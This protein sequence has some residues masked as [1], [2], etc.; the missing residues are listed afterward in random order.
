VRRGQAHPGER[1]GLVFAGVYLFWLGYVWLVVRYAIHPFVLLFVL[2]SGRAAALAESGGVWVRRSVAAAAFYVLLFGT[3]VTAI[4]EINGPQLHYFAGRITAGKYVDEVLYSAPSLKYAASRTGPADLVLAV[5]NIAHLYGPRLDRLHSFYYRTPR[6][7]ARP[8]PVDSLPYT[9]MILPRNEV[10]R[11]FLANQR[12]PV[13]KSLL[14]EDA[15]YRVYAIRQS[16]AA[17]GG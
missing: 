11:A 7:A 15:R 10:G 14:Y 8:H 5:N 16:P 3:L 1:A 13:R 9:M 2:T 17:D 6:H 4:L 12:K